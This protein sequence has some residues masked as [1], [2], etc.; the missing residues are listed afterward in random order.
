MD[1]QYEFVVV[2]NRLPVDQTT[3]DQG[4]TLWQTSPGGLVTAMKP[5]VSSRPS[6]WV[7]WAGSS[8]GKH[9]DPFSFEGTTLFPVALSAKDYADYYE[10]FSNS[11]LWPLFHDVIVPPTYHRHWWE[12]YRAM[13][14][15]FTEQA[16]AIAAEGGIVWVHDYQL[17]LVP[18]MLRALRPDL[19]IAFFLHIPFPA[20]GI[21]SQL[22]WRRDL[23]R[24]LMG[25]DVIGV[26]RPMDAANLRTA[27]RRLLGYTSKGDLVFVPTASRSQP[28][29]AKER[30]IVLHHYP[31][32]IDSEHYAE[33]AASEKIIE[34][35]EALKA[36]LGNPKKILLGVDRLDY[37][38]GIRHRLR[39]FEEL[40][41]SEQL[42]VEDVLLIQ[43]ASPSRERVEA[44]QELRDEIELTVGRI[45]GD[46]STMS[47][48]PV[49]YLHQSYPIEDMVS[50]YLAA[51]VL[52]VTALR[53]GMNLVSK[54]Y[55]ACRRGEGGVLVLSE[56]AGASD[57]L[58]Q[59]IK[60]NPHDI[61]GLKNAM[62]RALEMSPTQQQ[63]S[64]R[65]MYES[66]LSHNVSRWAESIL[67]RVETIQKTKNQQ[68]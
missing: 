19:T 32:S 41:A 33:L 27:V 42:S 23:L 18:A 58:T 12:R 25:A 39:A 35:S 36:A 53:D 9:I 21:F 26:Q 8:D 10:G 4:N 6:A 51:D 54:E 67:E 1:K 55:V 49:L 13:N 66:V 59:A 45:N 16:A 17:M 64:M 52:L 22:P 30:E 20:H 14:E 46:H 29:S 37:T 5:V 7:G 47:H 63:K 65:P 2:S 60:V 62:M 50:L 34:K 61:D 40:L 3:D 43:V 68:V 11:T 44:Y 48:S 15:R 38:K 57:E 56:F 31:I 24:G 28:R